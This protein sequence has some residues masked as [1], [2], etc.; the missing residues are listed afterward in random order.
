[1][2]TPAARGSPRKLTEAKNGLGAPSARLFPGNTVFELWDAVPDPQTNMNALDA[3]GTQ[4][5][6]TE[7]DGS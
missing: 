6:H 1:M 4:W 2:D 3:H 7:V 5:K